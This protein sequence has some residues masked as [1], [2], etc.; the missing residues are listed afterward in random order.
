VTLGTRFA[1]KLIRLRLHHVEIDLR[2]GI[3]SHAIK[4]ADMTDPVERD[5]HGY[6]ELRSRQ[7]DAGNHFSRRMLDLQTRVQFEEEE[8]ILSVTVEI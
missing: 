3:R 6:L 4:S 8:H 7:I 5:T 1:L 2:R